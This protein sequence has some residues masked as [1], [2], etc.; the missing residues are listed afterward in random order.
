AMILRP[1]NVPEPQSLYGIERTSDK[2]GND[3]Y[4]N[5][6]DFR[7]RNHSFDDLA[8]YDID[9]QDST[10]VIIQTAFGSTKLQGTISMCFD[11]TRIWAVFSTPPTSVAP[12]AHPMS[13]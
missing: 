8:G 13:S 12:T 2:L 5:Y 4:P 3:S 11:F 6:L 7:D 10:Q 1:L 9:R